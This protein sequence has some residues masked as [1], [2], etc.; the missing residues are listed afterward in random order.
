MREGGYTGAVSDRTMVILVGGRAALCR[1]AGIPSVVRHVAA[2]QQLGLRAIVVF[3][4]ALAALGAEIAGA[5]SG[6]C[7]CVVVE[8][9]EREL[10]DDNDELVIVSAADWYLSFGTIHSFAQRTHGFARARVVERGA[11]AAPLARI[12]RTLLPRVCEDLA[13][14]SV[15][16]IVEFA[17]RQAVVFEPEAGD[18]QRLSDDVSITAAEEK[19]VASVF[20]KPPLFDAGRPRR[21]LAIHLAKPL[22]RVGLDFAVLS[23]AKNAG[24][25]A[26]ATILF[27]PGYG[28]GLLGALAYFLVRALD[29]ALAV[30]ARA[31]IGENARREKLDAAGDTVMQLA[32]LWAI[33]LRPDMGPEGI[34]LASFAS[35]GLV[36][37]TGLA[38]TFVLR[39]LW[40]AHSSKSLVDEPADEFLSRFVQRDGAAVALIFAALIGRL[41]L[42]LWSAAAAAHLFYIIWL[43]ARSRRKTSLERFG[44]AG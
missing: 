34:G 40:A 18:R 27:A 23:M 12:P 2:A 39:D 4:R 37:A 16:R 43:T 11:P 10:G 5:V 36:I 35:L 22:A 15:A 13:T 9:L 1:V 7:P 21:E 19:L 41:D 31:S 8:D 17:T 32:V 30:A 29:G 38:W 33:A 6:R 20:G 24:G 44:A 42:F 25:L 26:A 3:P 14:E 28:A